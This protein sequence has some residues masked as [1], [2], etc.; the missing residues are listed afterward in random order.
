MG[1]DSVPASEL[2]TD[3]Q[4]VP[5]DGVEA[6]TSA[7][8]ADEQS[9]ALKEGLGFFRIALL[10]F[11]FIA[12]FVGAFI[13]F[14]TFSI[15]VAQR[16]RELALLRALGASRRQ[17]MT[18]V[19]VEAFLVGLFA[20][21]VGIVA[22]IAIA[23]GL[24]VLL[25]AFGIDLPSTSLVLLPRTIIV[26]LP[27]RFD[28]DRGRVVPARAEGRSRLAPIQALRESGEHDAVRRPPRAGA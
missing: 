12:L 5:P 20:A 14:N 28:R 17:V 13:I 3:I 21:V 22:G 4:V 16:T 2:R 15:I 10:V 8:V 27:H 1:D 7:S 19:V 18:S 26:S 9:K 11:A 24:K 25:G 23:A 6:V